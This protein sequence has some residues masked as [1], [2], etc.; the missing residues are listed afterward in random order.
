MQRYLMSLATV[1]LGLAV[2]G[3]AQACGG[4]SS[5]TYQQDYS[6]RYSAPRVYLPPMAYTHERHVD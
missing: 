5:Y 3:S 1:A 6:L 2:S 4:G